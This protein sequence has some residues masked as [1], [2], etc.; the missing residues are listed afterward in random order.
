VGPSKFEVLVGY[1]DIAMKQAV[2]VDVRTEGNIWSVLNRFHALQYINRNTDSIN[3][4]SLC[5]S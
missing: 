3:T 4:Q 2:G 1:P 5:I